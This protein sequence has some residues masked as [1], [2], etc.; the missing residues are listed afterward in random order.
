MKPLLVKGAPAVIQDLRELYVDDEKVAA[1]EALLLGYLK[2]MES[3]MTLDSAE[4]AEEQDP[5]VM[6]WLLYFISYHFMFRREYARALEFVNR[7]I[8][9]TP[10]LLE[11]Y[12]LKGKIYAKG[13]DRG[14]A[15]QL[16]EEARLMDMADRAINA[17]S[18]LQLVKAGR[19]AKGED[20]MGIFFADCGYESTVHDNQCLWFEQTV[21]RA[22]L[23]LGAPRESLKQ[24]SWIMG[25][26]QSMEDDQYDYYLY[27]MRKFTLQAF[28]GLMNLNSSELYLFAPIRKA[29]RDLVRLVAKVA[30][31][32]QCAER[33]A[34]FQPEYDTYIASEAYRSLQG[35]KPQ[36]AVDGDDDDDKAK[37]NDPEG[38]SRYLD[39]VSLS[40]CF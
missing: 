1:I 24:L 33:L 34:A 5:T 17:H 10:T 35:E 32:G 14:T 3:G 2:A 19:V 20:V 6:L 31:P 8:D 7:A 23:R 29:M 22:H 18:A 11:L 37:D 15:A 25:H 4:G 38:Y 16:F 12:T 39:L 26:L 40:G 13:G 28:E 27:S 9:H 21:A 30:D 36:G